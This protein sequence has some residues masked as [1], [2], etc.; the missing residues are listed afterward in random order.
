[1]FTYKGDKF[2]YS[3]ILLTELL[4]YIINCDRIE[5]QR[6]K[7]MNLEK[8]KLPR[9]IASIFTV[10]VTVAG[11][12]LIGILPA[13]NVAGGPMTLGD[14]IS[15]ILYLI[16]NTSSVNPSTIG[17]YIS[18]MLNVIVYLVTFVVA[19]VFLIKC[20]VSLARFNKEGSA[21]RIVFDSLKLSFTLLTFFGFTLFF[22]YRGIGVSVAIGGYLALALGAVAVLSALVNYFLVSERALLS[23]CLRVCFVIVGFAASIF[24][25]LPTLTAGGSTLTAGALLLD[26]VNGAI[27]GGSVDSLVLASILTMFV[28]SIVAYSFVSNEGIKSVDERR[29]NDGRS[30]ASIVLTGIALVLTLGALFGEKIINPSMNLGVSIYGILAI[31][32]M[33]LSL[34]LAILVFVFTK[35]EKVK[36]TP[37]E[38]TSSEEVEENEAPK[39]VEEPAEEETL[40][41]EEEVTPTEEEKVPEEAVVASVATAAIVEEEPE[42]VKEEDQVE[43]APKKEEPATKKEKSAPK[44]KA[45]AK[46]AEEKKPEEKKAEDKEAKKNASYH[47]SK[48]ASDNKWQVFR[49]GSEKVIKLFD[50]KVEAEEYTK[51]MAENQGVG[52]LSH[53]SKGKNKGRIQKK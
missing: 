23:K 51:R 16:Q 5:N 17:L 14:Y 47:I 38:F 43:E 12:V 11:L 53:A 10:V 30:V 35:K 32:L 36:V 34:A 18:S 24:A 40:V 6:K 33:A 27:S 52:Y 31:V 1:M 37:V 13:L 19:I 39:V 22:N 45:P 20:I 49:A 8:T 15:Q 41:S 42:P 7:N 2:E 9:L 4:T 25:L 46:K 26:V 48:R 28:F 44:K 3:Y 29:K 21:K 50:T